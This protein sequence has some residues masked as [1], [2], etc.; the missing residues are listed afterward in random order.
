MLPVQSG[1]CTCRGKSL[2]P[3]LGRPPEDIRSQLVQLL[4]RLHSFF[5]IGAL[6]GFGSIVC[7]FNKGGRGV[8]RSSPARPVSVFRARVAARPLPAQ[9]GAGREAGVS[10]RF[11][12]KIG[13]ACTLFKNWYSSHGFIIGAA[14]VSVTA[15]K[16]Y[17]ATLIKA[18]GCTA[19]TL[20]SWR[21]RNGLFPE[22]HNSGTWNRFSIIDMFVASIVRDLTNRGIPAQL[23][24]DAAM[25]AAPVL[26][27]LCETSAMEDADADNMEHMFLQ[28][29]YPI[30][31]SN[32]VLGFKLNADNGPEVGLLASDTSIRKALDR[33]LSDF[34]DLRELLLV[35]GS[36][37]INDVDFEN[38]H[39]DRARWIGPFSELRRAEIASISER[40]PPKAVA[41]GRMLAKKRKP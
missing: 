11:V 10:P 12:E 28:A 14:S 33:G 6:R 41:R 3:A 2:P 7:Q 30:A 22:T 35:A 29:A 16:F 27:T 9:R 24:V 21:T 5:I 1:T 17:T 8:G 40:K 13:A 31:R 4:L 15:K 20:R 38:A 23:A 32:V 39:G 26:T 18:A 19:D 25:A 34:V 36:L 37:L